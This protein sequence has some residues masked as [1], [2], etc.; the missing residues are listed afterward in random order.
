[1][2]FL[3]FPDFIK[4]SIDA[5]WVILFLFLFVG[6]RV[7]IK[8][9]ITPMVAIVGIWFM[10]V[11]VGYIFN[12]QSV[13]YFLW[14]LRNN[15]RFYVAFFAFA[16]FLSDDD[17]SS[18]FKLV[19]IL[20]WINA[21][22]SLFQFFVLGYKQDYLGGIFGVERGCNAYS[23]LLFA[24]VVSRSLLLYL[25]GSETIK[26]CALKCG[27]A[28]MLAAM[29]EV[30]FFFIL[31]VLFTLISMLLTRFSWKKLIIFVLVALLLMFSG[32]ILTTVFGSKE[33]LSFQRIAELITSENYSSGE[34]LGRFTAIPT[35]S[36]DIFKN[37]LERCFG[38]GLGNCDT[39]AFAICNTPFFQSH[40]YLHYSWFSKDVLHLQYEMLGERMW[41][42]EP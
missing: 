24:F 19:D 28:L 4:Y 27:V 9:T 1:M 23:T 22:A 32:T 17:I 6:K 29:A 34:D 21:V 20:F 7:L 42:W 36:K 15:F 3:H 10:Y 2:D 30:K 33:E 16:T 37:V 11:F 35:I 14:G 39:S 8:K 12:F 25:S 13:F 31:F 5:A 40:G 41:D 18:C 38:M 26:L